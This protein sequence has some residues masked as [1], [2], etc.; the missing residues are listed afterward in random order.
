[1][2]QFHDTIQQRCLMEN[3]IKKITKTKLTHNADST[4]KFILA[5]E[6]INKKG[7]ITNIKSFNREN[8]LIQIYEYNYANDTLLKETRMTSLNHPNRSVN[9]TTYTYSGSKHP[10]TCNFYFGQDLKS[11]LKFEYSKEGLLKTINQTWYDSK[12]YGKKKGHGKT[13]YTYNSEGKVTNTIVKRKIDGK[14]KK[15]FYS[16]KYDLKNKV[17][18][19]YVKYESGQN[20]MLLQRTEL[21]GNNRVI[22][23]KIYYFKNAT[24][25]TGTTEF[26]INKGD[27]F[28]K[29]FI[30]NDRGLIEKEVN[31]VNE[32]Q[33]VEI[34]YNY[35][36]DA[37]H[38]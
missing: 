4:G 23:E 10:E 35:T 22:S 14:V 13:R 20:K 1:M 11:S 2:A 33:V 30:Y 18:E 7:Y 36:A 19:K 29:K 9:L 28:Q 12:A 24:L 25:N 6:E 15:E 17:I 21:D 26:K 16:Y 32:S 38:R 31:Q 37:S 3:G 5:I 8:A 27:S 34:W